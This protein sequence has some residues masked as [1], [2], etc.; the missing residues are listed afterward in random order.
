MPTTYIIEFAKPVGA[1]RTFDWNT[2]AVKPADQIADPKRCQ[3][4]FYIG[5][6][7]D[8]Q[9]RF[10]EHVTG[11]G[12]ALCRAAIKRGVSIEIAIRFE[13]ENN[14]QAWKLEKVL[15]NK[16]ATAKL[17]AALREGKTVK[18]VPAPTFIKRPVTVDTWLDLH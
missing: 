5:W 18:G 17:V 7:V 1:P 9:N 16:K 8:M 11:K 13:F 12:S 6:A 2:G 14:E 3:A 15:K 10:D 4:K